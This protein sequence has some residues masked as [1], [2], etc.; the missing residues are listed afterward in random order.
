MF[1][2]EVRVYVAPEVGASTGDLKQVAGKR[3]ARDSEL[4]T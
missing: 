4:L 1:R 2:F 3:A